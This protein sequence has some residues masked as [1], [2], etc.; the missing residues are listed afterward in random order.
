M[1]SL[2]EFAAN[3]QTSEAT[4]TSP[5]LAIHVYYPRA[6]TDW[7]PAI[8]PTPGDPDPLATA[9]APQETHEH[10]RTEMGQAQAIQAEGANRRRT[11]APVFGLGD[12]VWLDARNI[13]TRRP[14]KKLD[15]HRLGPYEVF[16]FV[17]SNAARL[18]LP[19]TMRLH[20]VFH[21]SLLE[22]ACDSLPGQQSPPPPAVIVYREEEWEVERILDSRLYYRRLQDFVKW[23]GYGAPLWQPA[24]NMEHPGEAV[25]DFHRLH[26]DRLKPFAL[27]GARALGGGYC[28]GGIMTGHSTALSVDQTQHLGPAAPPGRS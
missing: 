9:T 17:G 2:A 10:L 13:T 7:R 18:R 24:E 23:K 6:T 20:P 27:S 11:P 12:W 26:P 1:A 4:H 15:H 25:Q 8:E 3:N 21:V 14:S 19:D 22:H 28:H 16:K 5:F